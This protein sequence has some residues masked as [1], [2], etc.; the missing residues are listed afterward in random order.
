M[1]KIPQIQALIEYP[2]S[3]GQPMT[4]SDPTRNYLV[5]CV[6]A[7]RLFFQSHPQVYVFGNRV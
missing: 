2:D 5:Y 4:E 1:V 7:L 3:D 6:E